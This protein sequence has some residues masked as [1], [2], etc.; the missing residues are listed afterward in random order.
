MSIYASPDDPRLS[1]TPLYQHQ[2]LPRPPRA[3]T[4]ERIRERQVKSVRHI[5]WPSCALSHAIH[6]DNQVPPPNSYKPLDE[7][8]FVADSVHGGFKPNAELVKDHFIR[9][10]RL[11]DKQ[12]LFIL[13]EVTELMRREPNM[14]V[15]SGPTTGM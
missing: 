12:A 3:S 10:G 2:E 9:E 8:F 5:S 14:L 13:K 1:R 15:L 4:P 7:D 11:T 6:Y